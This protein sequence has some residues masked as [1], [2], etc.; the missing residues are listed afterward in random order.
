MYQSFILLLGIATLFTFINSRY[1]KLPLT[2]GLMIL[3]MILSGVLIIIKFT[4]PQFFTVIPDIVEDIDFEHFLMN[5]ILSFL[6]FAGAVHIDIKELR[7]ERIP[8]FSFAVFGT[9]LSTFIIGYLTFIAFGA[10]GLDFSFLHCLLFGALISP[11]DPI[12]VLG[13][14]GHFKVRK[15]I[16]IKIEGESLFNDGIGIVIFITILNLIDGNSDGFSLTETSL[17]FLREAGGGVVFGIVIGWI[18]LLFLKQLNKD[19][20]NTI[21]ATLVVATGGYA[22]A[23]IIEVSGPLAMVSAGLIIGN[24][25]HK[26]A[27]KETER[28]INSFWKVID[29][30]FNSSLFVLM[31][32]AIVLIDPAEINIMAGLFAIVI[33]IIGR[34]IS[35]TI[36]YFIVDKRVRKFPWVNIKMVTIM[37]WSGLRGALAFALALTIDESEHGH[38]YIFITYCVV[39]FSI[40]VQGLT[41][42]KLIKALKV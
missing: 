2:I 40:I 29:I 20:D 6:L 27:E 18:S 11:T 3:G 13:I 19:P 32:M 14:F 1:M 31:G 34:F 21:M 7:K 36:P 30:V 24:W 9:L 38:F 5:G 22:L 26:H 28:L 23:N 39:A 37:T 8:V 10:L 33:V 42:P 16:S 12:A 35:V 41:I 17:L 4:L 15:D 25:V